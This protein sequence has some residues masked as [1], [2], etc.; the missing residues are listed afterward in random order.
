MPNK[1]ELLQNTLLKLVVRS[2]TDSDRRSIVLDPGELGYTTDTKRLYAG[3]GTTAGGVLVGNVFNGS[4]T[5]VTTSPGTPAIGDLAFDTSSKVLYK[6]NGGNPATIGS[7]EVIGGVYTARNRTIDISTTSISVCSLSANNISSD[8]LGRSITLDTGRIT[9]SST[10]AV[11]RIRPISTLVAMPSSVSFNEVAYKFPSAPLSANTFLRTDS[12]GNLSWTSIN[13]FLSSASARVTVNKG[14]SATVNGVPS[15]TFSLITSS[16]VTIG[17]VFL[18]TA[19]VTFD[20]SGT[21]TRNANVASVTPVDVATITSP[22]VIPT[23]GGVNLVAGATRFDVPGITGGYLITL[24]NNVNTSTAVV[25]I[26]IQN[27]A[28]FYEREGSFRDRSQVLNSYFKYFGT[29]QIYVAFYVPTTNL[30]GTPKE[31]LLTAGY[32]DQNTRF[33]V[34]VYD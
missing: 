29:N 33:S 21:I 24:N 18:P 4:R 9:L 31:N 1:I 20:Q 11:D 6:Y 28:Y 8:A 5:P 12:A 16:N 22:G 14:L 10:I 32:N 23:I 34:T 19:H 17:G 7:W 26:K 15:T 25:D 30:V 3:D 2:G 27:A 13:T